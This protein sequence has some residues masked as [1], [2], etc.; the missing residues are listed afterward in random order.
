[1]NKHADTVLSAPY[2]LETYATIAPALQGEGPPE[3]ALNFAPFGETGKG[4]G[5]IRRRESDGE[6]AKVLNI[7]KVCG[8]QI[9]RV[10]RSLRALRVKQKL[11]GTGN[12]ALKALRWC[13]C[14][15]PLR[16]HDKQQ[17]GK[18]YP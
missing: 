6:S 4:T 11:W 8:L 2:R 3:I 9:S 15:T 5:Q 16:E 1:M 18:R 12:G 7:E 17:I 10:S 13:D 14:C